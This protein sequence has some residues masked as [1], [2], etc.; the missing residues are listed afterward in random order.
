MIFKPRRGNVRVHKNFVLQFFFG[1]FV[2]ACLPCAENFPSLTV[3]T[4]T[5]LKRLFY[6]K[7]YLSH[8]FMQ[9][10]DSVICDRKFKRV[11]NFKP[12]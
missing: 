10:I 4:R 7:K 1:N 2:V 9:K 6:S 3:H 5:L 11:I 12:F 8:W